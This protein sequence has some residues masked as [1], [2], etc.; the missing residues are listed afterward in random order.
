MNKSNLLFIGAIVIYVI[1]CIGVSK[2]AA[3]IGWV[4]WWTD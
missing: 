4:K 3:S 1:V 2:A